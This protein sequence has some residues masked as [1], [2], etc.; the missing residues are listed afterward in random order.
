MNVNVN[1]RIVH[2]SAQFTITAAL[3]MI[4]EHRQKSGQGDKLLS[5]NIEELRLQHLVKK[6]QDSKTPT[7]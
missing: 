5:Q 4:L 3:Q 7:Q 6:L 2:T 1:I